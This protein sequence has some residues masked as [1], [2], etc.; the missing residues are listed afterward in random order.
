MVVPE[1]D[2]LDEKDGIIERTCDQCEDGS[3]TGFA[4]TC[5]Y[6]EDGHLICPKIKAAIEVNEGL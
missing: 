1:G 5:P 3:K 6:G 4:E 2:G